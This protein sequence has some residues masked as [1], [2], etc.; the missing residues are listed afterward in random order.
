MGRRKH[1]S[2]RGQGAV[3]ARSDTGE[4][5]QRAHLQAR[6]RAPA[7]AAQA[8]AARR[9]YAERR[10]GERYVTP[11]QY[12]R[13]YQGI[14]RQGRGSPAHHRRRGLAEPAPR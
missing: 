7:P 10:S 3:A 5:G 13:Y 9:A 1:P 2:Y 12:L 11:A 14:L 4:R 6:G 8:Q